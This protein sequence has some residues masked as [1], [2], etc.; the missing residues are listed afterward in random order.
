MNSIPLQSNQALINTDGESQA[1][2]SSVT[3]GTQTENLSIMGKGIEPLDPNRVENPFKKTQP[4]ETSIQLSNLHKVLNE[5][6]IAEV[7]KLDNQRARIRK[8]IINEDWL[9]LK[10]YSKY[11]HSLRKDVSVNETGCIIYDGKL[12]LPPQLRDIALQSILKTHTGQAGMMFMAQL[13]W[14][15]R[16][17]REIVLIEQSCKPCTTIGKKL[18]PVI[19]KYAHT[20]LKTL[21]EPNQE[22]KLDFTG[23]ITDNNK[24]TYILVSIY[25]Y[26]RYP[27]AKAYH[28]CDTETA[29]N[30][31]K[32]YKKFHRIPRTIRCDQ[33]QAFKSQNFEI[34]CNDNHIKLI[35]APVGD[36]GGTGLVEGM[37][38]T[39]KRRLSVLN[40]DPT[41]EKK[42]LGDKIA[43]V[44]ENIKLIPNTANCITPFDTSFWQTAQHKAN[45]RF[46]KPSSKKSKLR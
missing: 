5:K 15:P 22:L 32:S 12:Y 40:I 23:P 41:W 17:H 8:L 46:K 4:G 20:E 9:A 44:I 33:A 39:L 35:L 11:W 7:I 26:S 29:L 36:H 42:T 13:L 43:H 25:T 6:F 10:H 37:I 3:I 1:N 24:D 21:T 38:Q 45:E 16:I 30:Y 34:F 31:L 14:F 28:N 2:N 27:H 18:K 19:T